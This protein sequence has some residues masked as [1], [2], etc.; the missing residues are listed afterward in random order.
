MTR[1]PYVQS[2]NITEEVTMLNEKDL[3][4]EVT[5]TFQR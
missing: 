3:I 4:E 2:G 1:F 5:L